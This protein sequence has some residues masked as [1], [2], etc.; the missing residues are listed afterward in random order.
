[1]IIAML[2]QASRLRLES[3]K[4]AAKLQPMS[5]ATIT[6]MQ[7]ARWARTWET[8]STNVLDKR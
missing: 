8:F 6:R 4:A 5:G 7:Q 3:K 1:M 2:A